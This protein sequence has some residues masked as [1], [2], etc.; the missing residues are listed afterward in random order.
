MASQGARQDGTAR[1]RNDRPRDAYRGMM[2]PEPI[3]RRSMTAPKSCWPGAPAILRRG[4]LPRRALDA[5]GAAWYAGKMLEC[6][7]SRGAQGPR[8]H[9]PAGFDDRVVCEAMNP[10][11]RSTPLAVANHSPARELATPCFHIEPGGML[12]TSDCVFTA[13][14][15]ARGARE[16]HDVD[17]GVATPSSS[18]ARSSPVTAPSA[19]AA[20]AI[21]F[22]SGRSTASCRAARTWR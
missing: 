6:G 17:P 3:P 18:K 21:R 12:D 2:G 22:W 4:R 11:R 5:A 20:R 9:S 13:A 10:I 16:R 7:A 15:R 19:S 1:R 8:L 14:E